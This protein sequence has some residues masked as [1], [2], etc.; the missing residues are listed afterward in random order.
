M[1]SASPGSVLEYSPACIPQVPMFSLKMGHTTV[2][3]AGACLPSLPS[4]CAHDSLEIS[5]LGHFLF[6]FFFRPT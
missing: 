2:Q 3:R 4:C 6:N 5:D 1:A